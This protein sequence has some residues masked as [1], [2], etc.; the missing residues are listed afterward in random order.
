MSAPSRSST[1]TVIGWRDIPAQ[2]V[3]AHGRNK[4][5][6]ELSPRFQA[7]IDRAAMQA[8][9]IGTDEYLTQWARS[10]RD[11][12][13]DLNTEARNAASQLELAYDRPR[14]ER[15]IAAAGIEKDT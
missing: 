9:L 5:R 11:C 13:D 3:A 14:L 12:S 15:L 8:G 6:I 7:A 2:V 10:A 1:L 4:V